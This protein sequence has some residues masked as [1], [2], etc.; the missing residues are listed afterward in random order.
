MGQS[1]VIGFRK[2]GERV[3]G[4][5]IV[6]APRTLVVADPPVT[7]AERNEFLA[8]LGVDRED[9]HICSCGCGCRRTQIGGGLCGA[10]EYG[11]CLMPGARS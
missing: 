8:L 10:C 11:D 5:Y 9:R 6:V 7:P 3:N 2:P 4:R 1:L